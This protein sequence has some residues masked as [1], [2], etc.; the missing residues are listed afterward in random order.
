[1]LGSGDELE[2][3]FFSTF[4]FFFFFWFFNFFFI[5]FNY[6]ALRCFFYI[7]GETAKYFALCDVRM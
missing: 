6:E 7:K 2:M 4:G 3:I 5:R 1:M